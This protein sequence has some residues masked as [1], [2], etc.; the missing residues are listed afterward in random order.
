MGG[1]PA[2]RG[3][4]GSTHAPGISSICATVSNLLRV[5]RRVIFWFFSLYVGTM[6]PYGKAFASPG[7]GRCI[8]V[9]G[10][11]NM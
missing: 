4:E 10:L 6:Y 9:K 7:G 2:H 8:V 5:M 11:M 1:P 3:R